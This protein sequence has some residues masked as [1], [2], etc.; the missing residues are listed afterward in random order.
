MPLNTTSRLAPV[1]ANTAIHNV[2]SPHSVRPKNTSL[3]PARRQ[4]SATARV[5]VRRDS[6]T[7]SGKLAQVVVHEDDVGRFDRGIGAG[8]AHGEADIGAR[9][10]R[11]VVDAVADHARSDRGARK[12]SMRVELVLGQQVAA[13]VVDAGL[14]PPRSRT[15]A[16][17]S[18]EQD[19]RPD[20]QR[21]SLDRPR[22]GSIRASRRPPRSAASAMPWRHRTIAVLPCCSS[23]S[24]SCCK[25]GLSAPS[26][27]AS[28]ALP[29]WYSIPLILPFTPRP[30]RVAK[31]PTS[32][33]FFGILRAQHRVRDRVAGQGV[34]A[35]GDLQGQFARQAWSVERRSRR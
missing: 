8:R 32:S 23:P 13:R 11:R 16:P 35:G 3:T 17:L 21:A 18:P 5:A 1:S 28:R 25:P 2:A 9:Q 22:R 14:R 24:S 27:R 33:R 6:R 30:G 26:S 15:V 4:C 29:R 10:R 12:A 20:A 34:Q 31:S 7:N 19:R